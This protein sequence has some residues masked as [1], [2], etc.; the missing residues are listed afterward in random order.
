MHSLWAN[1]LIKGHFDLTSSHSHPANTEDINP[2]LIK[3]ST[4]V[5]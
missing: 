3:H 4:R 2:W 1:A 5:V